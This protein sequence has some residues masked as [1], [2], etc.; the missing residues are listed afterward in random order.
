MR[1]IIE[2]NALPLLMTSAIEAYDY[3]HKAHK[4]GKG[5]SQLETYGLLWGYMIPS[6]TEG[7]QDKIVVTTCTVETSALRH[8]DW[9]EPNYD[10]I[11]A[12]KEM[13]EQYWPHLELVGTFHSHPYKSLED[14]KNREG[15]AW[16]ASDGDKLHWPHIHE[17]IAYNQPGLAHLIITVTQ[18][19]K[20]GWAYPEKQYDSFCSGY[21]FVAGLKKIWLTS[22]ATVQDVIFEQDEEKTF[23]VIKGVDLDIPSLQTRMLKNNI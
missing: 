23:S 17:C 6:K 19:K 3:E 5:S 18:L 4:N 10:S 21:S 1:I 15:P 2:D 16:K 8:Q 12:K 13:I 7:G 9:V 14:M 22:Y 11:Q 20:K